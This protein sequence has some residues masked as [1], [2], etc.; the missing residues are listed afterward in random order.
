MTISLTEKM[1]NPSTIFLYLISLMISFHLTHAGDDEVFPR[2]LTSAGQNSHA[3][4]SSTG[5]WIV[6]QHQGPGLL[7]QSPYCNQIYQMKPDGTELIRL[8]SGQGQTAHPVYL[9]KDI[10][11][12]FST[13]EGSK[14]GCLPGVD[15]AF[16]PLVPSY[17]IYGVKLDG[18]DVVP[19][20]PGAPS[21]YHAEAAV[22]QNKIIFTS[23]RDSSYNLYSAR[24][25]LFGSLS[26]VKK[27]TQEYGYDGGTAFSPDCSKIVWHARHPKTEKE[28]NLI[29][30]D[31]A[32]DRI[33]VKDLEIW[34]GQPDGSGAHALTQLHTSS[35]D[36]QFTPDGKKVLFSSLNPGSKIYSL[37]L[38]DID[39]S[40][41]QKLSLRPKTGAPEM[42]ARSPIFSPDGK[43]LIFSSRDSKV[44]SENLWIL[45]WEPHKIVQN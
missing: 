23:A 22:C 19:L 39:G 7:G 38:I 4:W 28:A 12:A 33:P 42:D 29:Q 13:I 3:R 15:P 21:V 27:I 26:E 18:T 43:Q 24:L 45:N 6:F 35:R 5:K 9:P 25:D 1:P 34:I 14:K 31:L 30:K 2:P 32:Q 17:Q 8:S 20:D 16:I 37:Y 11:V 40:H 41:L 44:S 36:P 10:R